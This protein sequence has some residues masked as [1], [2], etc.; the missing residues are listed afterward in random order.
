MSLTR[1][2]PTGTPISLRECISQTASLNDAFKNKF[3]LSCGYAR[4]KKLRNVPTGHLF[5]VI[6]RCVRQKHGE[7]CIF[8]PNTR[9]HDGQRRDYGGYF[10]YGIIPLVI[11]IS[12]LSVRIR[13]ITVAIFKWTNRP[14]QRIPKDLSGKEVRL[15]VI[16]DIWRK[17]LMKKETCG[18]LNLQFAR[19]LINSS[20]LGVQCKHSEAV[21]ELNTSSREPLS[22]T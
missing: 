21:P 10:W 14:Q 22:L 16:A 5:S 4:Q 12:L 17:V 19:W 7:Q 9:P 6:C 18:A 11:K 20:W 15:L 8:S 2:H 1:R 3:A 13:V